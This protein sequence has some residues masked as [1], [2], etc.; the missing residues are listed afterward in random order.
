MFILV[1]DPEF[2]RGRELPAEK[3]SAPWLESDSYFSSIGF[4]ENIASCSAEARDELGRMSK[5]MSPD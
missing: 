3:A 4:R 2:R 1:R 5:L